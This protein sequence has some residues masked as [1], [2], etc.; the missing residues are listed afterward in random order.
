MNHG[1]TQEKNF[2]LVLHPLKDT[3]LNDI[4]NVGNALHNYIRWLEEGDIKI[5]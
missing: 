3:A 1:E 4:T 2:H 5:A